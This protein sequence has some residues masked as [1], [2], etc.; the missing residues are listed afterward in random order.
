VVETRHAEFLEDDM[1]RGSKVA[2]DISFEEKRVHAPTPMFQEPYFML[3]VVATPTV[4]SDTVVPAPVVSSPVPI[5]NENSEPV[6]QDPLEPHVEH[7]EEQQQPHMAPNN[8]GLRRSQRV[9]RSAISD[10]YE[11]Y[12]TEEYHMEDDPTTYE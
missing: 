10:D 12:E 9:R 4:V 8:D 1:I 3:P 7:E 11:V 6:L 2:Q 5:I